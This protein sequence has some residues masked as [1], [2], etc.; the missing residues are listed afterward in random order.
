MI[1][2][3]SWRDFPLIFNHYHISNYNHW[4]TVILLS[5][6]IIIPNKSYTLFKTAVIFLITYT[7][8]LFSTSVVGPQIIN[9]TSITCI[10]QSRIHII[11][12][13]MWLQYQ[14]FIL[15]LTYWGRDKKATIFQMTFFN[16]CSW[17]KLYQFRL[18][19]HWHLFLGVQLTIFQHW[20]R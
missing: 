8:T 7:H 10:C 12:C 1:S 18:K 16:G 6:K 17:M 3:H 13:T 20:F 11:V 4:Q 2:G 9:S 19:F 5:T 14:T 15:F